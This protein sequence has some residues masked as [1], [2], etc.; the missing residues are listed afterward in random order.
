M[1]RRRRAHTVP[2]EVRLSIECD[3]R[4]DHPVERIARVRLVPRPDLPEGYA[5]RVEY[6]R[7]EQDPETSDYTMPTR[8][9]DLRPH[10]TRRFACPLCRRDI[11]IEDANLVRLVLLLNTLERRRIRLREMS[12]AIVINE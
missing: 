4:E 6:V 7:P 11:P 10:M 5:V 12:S 9:T 8:L 2:G 1:S 3:G